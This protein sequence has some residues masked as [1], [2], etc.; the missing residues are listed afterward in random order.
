M[1]EADTCT[2]RAAKTE[3][4]DQNSLNYVDRS[5]YLLCVH[6]IRVIKR[7]CVYQYKEWDTSY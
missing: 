4:L 2:V 5:V 6:K 1:G 3:I 7:I